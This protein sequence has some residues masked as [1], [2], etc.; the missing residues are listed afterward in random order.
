MILSTFALSLE[1]VYIK[2]LA[3][4][5]FTKSILSSLLIY[6]AILLQPVPL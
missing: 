6:Y 2:L 1:H 5:I 4:I 3:S